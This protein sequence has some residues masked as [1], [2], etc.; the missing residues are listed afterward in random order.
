MFYSRNTNIISNEPTSPGQNNKTNMNSTNSTGNGI[1][2]LS[3]KKILNQLM[4]I[5]NASYAAN[6]IKTLYK[7]VSNKNP[8]K[9]E[10]SIYSDENKDPRINAVYSQNQTQNIHSTTF[11][12]IRPNSRFSLSDPNEVLQGI[13]S[14]ERKKEN[15]TTNFSKTL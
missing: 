3:D 13:P 12:S 9:Y 1:F 10:E 6:L 4:R 15:K 14:A 8:E 11:T 5:K 2:N 7:K